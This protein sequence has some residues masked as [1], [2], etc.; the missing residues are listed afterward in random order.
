[1]LVLAT[2]A[3][4]LLAV[5]VFRQLTGLPPF[6]GMLSGL[7]VMWLLTDALHYGEDRRYPTVSQ[8]G[9][10]VVWSCISHAAPMS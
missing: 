6:L 10:S 1:M 8:V 4:A 3:G 9:S 7:G 2:G 5:P